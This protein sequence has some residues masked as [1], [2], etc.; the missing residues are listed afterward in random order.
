V[1]VYPAI[2]IY[3]GKA[4]RMTRGDYSTVEQVAASPLEAAKRLVNEG[5]EW[6]HIV[7][8]DGSRTGKPANLEAIRQIANRFTVKIQAGGGIRDFD[9]AEAFAEAGASRIVVGT[10]A[11]DDP[12]LIGRLVDRHADG[13]AVSVDAR[14]GMVTTDGWT[15]ATDVR[16]VDLVQRLAIAGVPI[17]IY[18][19]VSVDG[20][21][22]G[23]DVPSLEAV[24]R[25]FGGD[26]IYSGGVGSVD[27]IKALVKLRHRGIRGV[28]VGRALYMGK[29]TL[30]D[31]LAA[32][33]A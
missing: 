19:N 31:A 15:E 27:D 14:N 25:A 11:V 17:V 26:V 28:I 29:F 33:A 12:E 13:M 3:Q 22:Q 32:A 24:A 5:A 23:I 2:D 1:I 16:A 9:T 7:D 10:A 8:I 18:T 6:L 4:V 20:T 30:R 21:L